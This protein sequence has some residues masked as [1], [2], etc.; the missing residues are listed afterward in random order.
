MHFRW[1]IKSALI[2]VALMAAATPLFSEAYAVPTT[3]AKYP[4][5]VANHP[6][7]GPWGGHILDLAT[8][9]DATGNIKRMYAATKG[10]LYKFDIFQNHWYESG[11]GIPSSKL[12][13]VDVC[14]QSTGNLIASVSAP[15][16]V[17]PLQDGGGGVYLSGDYGGTWT[18][19]D[20]AKFI[21]NYK[22]PFNFI[23]VAIDP[24][25]TAHLFAAANDEDKYGSTER[26][27]IF[28]STDG[29]N[30]WLVPDPTNGGALSPKIEMAN[31]FN[32]QKMQVATDGTL[33]YHGQSPTIYRYRKNA[34]SAEALKSFSLTN[35]CNVN[36]FALVEG[37]PRKLLVAAGLCGLWQGVENGPLVSDWSWTKIKDAPTAADGA[38]EISAVAVDPTNQ[39]H[40]FYSAYDFYRMGASEV[41][42]SADGGLNVQSLS[43][44]ER[45]MNITHIVADAGGS[46]IAEYNSGLFRRGLSGGYQY[47]GA[48]L[49]AHEVNQFD[50]NPSGSNSG[51]GGNEIAVTGGNLS[52]GNGNGGVSIW[53]PSVGWSRAADTGYD[54]GSATRMIGYATAN[55]LWLSVEGFNIFS[56]ARAT[57]LSPFAWS[58]KTLGIG[59]SS[60]ALNTV[61]LITFA[62]DP[63]DPIYQDK[64]ILC[65]ATMVAGKG[66]IPYW[67]TAINDISEYEEGWNTPYQ[68][69]AGWQNWGNWLAAAD[70]FN[71]GSFYILSGN[72]QVGV[73]NG[74]T[75]G[76]F[77][78]DWVPTSINASGST[79]MVD[80]YAPVY[81]PIS[82]QSGILAESLSASTNI[83][84]GLLMGTASSGLMRSQDGG[85]SWSTVS[86][87]GLSTPYRVPFA[88]IAATENDN[89]MSAF[90]E[91]KG[92]YLTGNSGA[93]W[94]LFD[95]GLTFPGGM[96]EVTSMKF[97][98]D[99]RALVAGLRGRG[100]W[101]LY[102]GGAP[103]VTVNGPTTTPLG[104]TLVLDAVVTDP[105]GDSLSVSTR[106]LPEGAP[107]S[108]SNPSWTAENTPPTLASVGNKYTLAGQTLSFGVSATD[109]I[110]S[111]TF[112]I[113]ATDG[114]FTIK[115][116]VTVSATETSVGT[117]TITASGSIL[118]ASYPNKATFDGTNFSWTPVAGEAGQNFTVTFTA[119]DNLGA[120][121][122]ETIT[123]N[124]NRKPSIVLGTELIFTTDS[125]AARTFFVSDPDGDAIT[126]GATGLPPWLSLNSSTVSLDGNPPAS[127]GGKSYNVTITATDEH[128]ASIQKQTTILV[129]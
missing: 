64:A 68:M 50:F 34:S 31:D 40:I 10:G 71:A 85:V 70:P 100:L 114:F 49:C 72:S 17:D 116:N 88:D 48:G 94:T 119:T 104:T 45:Q 4:P 44:P 18:R 65:A 56:G 53:T 39:S 107:I 32:T 87:P 95:Q 29:G 105:D 36:D 101:S 75:L 13:S 97:T 3:W 51:T 37:S 126:L 21:N 84:G 30:T 91:G 128:G 125:A 22:T 47:S 61:N 19:I 93:Q 69:P 63:S 90:V 12:T 2:A 24:A 33:Y 14:Q 54:P 96:P 115:K 121:A 57:A 11:S 16:S 83:D 103:V 35:P 26:D 112:E 110:P 6:G 73:G 7:G 120:A 62:P 46:Y 77:D 99:S 8:E 78:Y 106:Q 111:A 42:E 58:E 76:Y 108:G 92:F 74:S 20:P 27:I 86:L 124:V 55:K 122:S 80:V 25:D 117:P 113:T 98:P 82:A 23:S 43:L 102:I 9:Y 38:P 67:N 15:A 127:E 118:G 1:E 28:E 129:N 79:L 60:T 89:L 52:S 59:S 41:F 5:A 81:T 123:I 109:Q 66:R